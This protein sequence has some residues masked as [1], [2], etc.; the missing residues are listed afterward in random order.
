MRPHE[1]IELATQ[2]LHDFNQATNVPTPDSQHSDN[3]WAAPAEDW[4]KINFDA[5]VN[6]DGSG[7]GLGSVARDYHGRCLAWKSSFHNFVRGAE[8]GEALAA[9]QAVEMC[10]LNAWDRCIIEGNCALII[11]K[12]NSKNLDL[13]SVSSLIYDILCMCPANKTIRFSWVCRT[14]NNVAHLLARS[15]SFSHE[16]T[17]S[18]QIMLDTLR[19]D[20][21]G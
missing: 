5:A 6:A 17:S 11:K 20:A 14:T 3:K 21:L 7:A 2:L 1:C 19:A 8:H 15:T 12:L 13:S 18:P 16:G 10:V 9:R 4:V